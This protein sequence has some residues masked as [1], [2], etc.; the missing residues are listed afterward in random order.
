MSIEAA[1]GTARAGDRLDNFLSAA[2]N[3]FVRHNMH[4]R[5][6]VELLHKHNLCESGERMVPL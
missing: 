5:F 2:A 6:G 4:D 3:L 1:N